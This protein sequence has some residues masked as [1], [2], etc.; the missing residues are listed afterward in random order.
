MI[1]MELS[2]IIISETNVIT[3]PAIYLWNQPTDTVNITPEWVTY[4]MP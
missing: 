1:H 4:T 2:R 3:Y